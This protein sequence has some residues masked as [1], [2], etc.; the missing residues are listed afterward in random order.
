MNRSWRQH[1][2]TILADAMRAP[3]RLIR[4]TTPL[5]DDEGFAPVFIVGSGRCGSTLLRRMLMT[6]PQIH[7]PPET[8]MLPQILHAFQRRRDLPWPELVRMTVSRFEYHRDFDIF[9]MS[10]RHVAVELLSTAK[11]QRSLARILDAIYRAH[12]EQHSRPTARWGD[13]TPYNVYV[14]DDIMRTFPD[15]QFVILIRDGVDVVESMLSRNVMAST[16]AEGAE[17]WR[18]A[19]VA[20]ERFARRHPSSCHEVRYESLVDHPVQEMQRLCAFLDLE[21]VPAMI[22]SLAS[23]ESMHDV[24][25]FEH[26]EETARP[27]TTSHIGKGRRNLTE[28]QRRQLDALIGEDLR[29]LNYPAA[30]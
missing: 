19:V 4:G 1:G 28:E 21:F 14:M 7:I 6:S 3:L 12:A 23:A 8:A 13:K 11:P 22:D 29:R 30:M 15:V 24:Q 2:A 5:H 27:V 16:L 20:G 18:S 9:N 17:R 26:F 10:L 25:R